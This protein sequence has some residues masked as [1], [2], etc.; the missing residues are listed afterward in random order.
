LPGEQLGPDLGG[1]NCATEISA[2]VI[3]SGNNSLEEINKNP[4]RYQNPIRHIRHQDYNE[5]QNNKPSVL[6][7]QNKRNFLKLRPICEANPAGNKIITN[8]FIKTKI[9]PRPAKLITTFGKQMKVTSR[10]LNYSID[11]VFSQKHQQ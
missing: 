5:S 9:T 6:S 4:V 11:H 3:V 7:A 8:A 1:G 10:S 2:K